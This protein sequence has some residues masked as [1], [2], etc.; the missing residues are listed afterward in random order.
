MSSNQDKQLYYT[1]VILILIYSYK[2]LPFQDLIECMQ[3]QQ[4]TLTLN[5]LHH[6]FLF[7]SSYSHFSFIICTFD[8]KIDLLHVKALQDSIH[9]MTF[10]IVF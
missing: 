1:K 4:I 7:P 5:F 10:F 2:C 8:N 6:I 3:N 9:L